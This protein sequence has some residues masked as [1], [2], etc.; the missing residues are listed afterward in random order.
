MAAAAE[1]KDTI[2]SLSRSGKPAT[3]VS[4]ADHGGQ[5]IASAPDLKYYINHEGLNI[6]REHVTS[7]GSVWS[8]ADLDLL[9]ELYARK[10]KLREIL[11]AFPER[12]R[13]SVKDKLRYCGPRPSNWTLDDRRLLLAKLKGGYSYTEIRS[14]WLPDRSIDAMRKAAST[15]KLRKQEAKSLSTETA[16]VLA[17]L[18]RD[19]KTPYEIRQAL[20]D[21]PS[22]SW[23]VHKIR[24]QIRDVT[25]PPTKSRPLYSY[26]EDEW[27]HVLKLHA[28]GMTTAQISAV[29]N[30]SPG[31]IAVKLRANNM[32]ENK[33]PRMNKTWTDAEQDSLKPYIHRRIPNISEL[34]SALTNRTVHA[35]ITKISSLRAE[36][37]V[38]LGLKGKRWTEA[39]VR[40]I[41]SD[42]DE[43]LPYKG[44]R[45]IA[46]VAERL[47]RSS[48]SV[49]HKLRALHG[50]KTAS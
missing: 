45:S 44:P 11:A 26:S 3:V 49:H 36:H 32:T 33:L 40:I 2:D 28:Q 24:M 48:K 1:S 13:A 41:Q 29:V 14:R 7:Q 27:Q 10:A 22:L 46:A 21:V 23:H 18:V 47:G 20:P 34:A 31:G 42:I 35:I 6:K 5:P 4:T 37:N 30:R 19:D 15:D 17:K 25:T 43:S 9:R 39:E 16:A 8:A 12:T 50:Q 38:A